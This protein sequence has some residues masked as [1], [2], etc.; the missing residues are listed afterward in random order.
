MTPAQSRP[1]GPANEVATFEMPMYRPE[2]V[3]WE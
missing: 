1:T 3:P 2:L